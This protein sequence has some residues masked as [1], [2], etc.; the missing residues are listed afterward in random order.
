MPPYPGKRCE[1]G[2]GGNK[3]GDICTGRSG[4]FAA[5][6]AVLYFN[7]CGFDIKK[8]VVHLVNREPLKDEFGSK[9]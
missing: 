1:W 9:K 5:D 6:M 7:F 4:R 2:I 3:R 8:R